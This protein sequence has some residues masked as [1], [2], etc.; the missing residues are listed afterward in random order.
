MDF[1]EHKVK[2]VGLTVTFDL[3]ALAVNMQDQHFR[4][5]QSFL[6][7]NKQTNTKEEGVLRDGAGDCGCLTN[8]EI[9]RFTQSLI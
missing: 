2:F 6:F 4:R 1:S 7:Q 9:I 5:S 3:S 8:V